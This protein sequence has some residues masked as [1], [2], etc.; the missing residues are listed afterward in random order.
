MKCENQEA[1]QKV[2]TGAFNVGMI[3]K[4]RED[5]A[6]QYKLIEKWTA[7]LRKKWLCNILFEE[8]K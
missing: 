5:K 2:R 1:L 6:N 3:V 4:T 8:D 7:Q